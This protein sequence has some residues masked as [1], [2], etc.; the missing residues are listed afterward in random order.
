MVSRTSVLDARPVLRGSQRPRILHV[1]EFV[2]STG[3]EAV[4]LARMAGLEPDPWQEFVITNA[5]GERAD[6]LWAARRVGVE[7][8]RQNG[9]GGLLE[10]RELAGLFLL[11]ERLIIHS[12][13][14]FA[15][16]GEALA[17][18]DAILE[19]CPDLSRRVRVLKRSHG[20]EG[21]YLKSGQRLRYKTR[22]KGGG[23]GFTADCVIL[24][25]AMVIP[26]AM[27]GA[28]FP[29]LRALP[30]PQI[31]YTGSAVDQESME[32]GVV[33]ARLREQAVRGEG[34]RL[35][36]FG[37]SAPFEHPDRVPEGAL[38]DP[39][40][41]ALANPALGIRIDA[42]YMAQELEAMDRRTFAVELLGVGDWPRVTGDDGA[43]I[44]VKRWLSLRD[45]D[46]RRS[47]GVVFSFDVDPDRRGGAICAAGV[48]PDG[49]SHVEVVEHERGTGWIAPR[50]KAL[51]DKHEPD[52]IVC[53]A[54]SPAASLVD[55]LHN[56]GVTVETVSSSEHA[57][58]CGVFYDAVDQGTVR[59]L[60]TG[61]LVMALKG[62]VK[63]PLGDAW[64][65]SRKSS[66]VDITPLVGCTLALWRARQGAGGDGLFV[67]DEDGELLSA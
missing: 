29:T 27:H 45:P 3:E 13:H 8:A 16:A 62:A 48:R 9:K 32:H 43:V 15:T 40:M 6:G 60:G 1:P 41:W 57:S 54:R 59:H 30:N 31:W 5:L 18:M 37:W 21:V 56:E 66:A 42:E 47:G 14:E 67:F 53:D 10:I 51:R 55:D 39:E 35:A 7:V 50:L 52:A 58:A 61:E 46:S 17:R 11:G 34:D 28:L 49:L 44:S 33:F 20:E 26:E 4:E 23:R 64:A 25:E 24:D 22:T 2:T 63:R 12:A 19:G 36:Y 38:E 65:W